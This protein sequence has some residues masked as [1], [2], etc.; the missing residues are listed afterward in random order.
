MVRLTATRYENSG[1]RPVMGGRHDDVAKS[2][3]HAQGALSRS[4]NRRDGTRMVPSVVI[5]R[6]P[7]VNEAIPMP[8]GHGR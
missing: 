6:M 5:T 7:E 8:L 2:L 4:D 3:S 1:D